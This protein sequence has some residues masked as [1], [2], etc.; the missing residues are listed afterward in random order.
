MQNCSHYWLSYLSSIQKYLVFG[1]FA[2]LSPEFHQEFCP[3]SSL[4]IS[5]GCA[6]IARVHHGAISSV[7]LPYLTVPPSPQRHFGSAAGKF[8]KSRWSRVDVVHLVQL[9]VMG[10]NLAS[11]RETWDFDAYRL[12][13]RWWRWCGAVRAWLTL[14]ISRTAGTIA[15][16]FTIALWRQS[17]IE[18]TDIGTERT[19]A[20]A[21]PCWSSTPATLWVGLM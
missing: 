20:T 10:V 3:R 1:S 13:R 21:R 16:A 6:E 14:R 8:D 5:R 18:S 4:G 7:L 19:S 12:R 2:P 15:A 17:L 11:S 9:C